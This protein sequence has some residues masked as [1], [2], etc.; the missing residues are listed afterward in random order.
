MAPAER[1]ATYAP[2]PTEATVIETIRYLFDE[3]QYRAYHSTDGLNDEDI[4]V[5]PGHG[6]WPIGEILR[7]QVLLTQFILETMKQGCTE[8]LPRFDFGKRGARKLAP[9]LEFR[10]LLNQ[11]FRATLAEMTPGGLMATRPD[12]PPDDWKDWPVLQ[13][14]LRPLTD[15]A[16]HTGQINYARRQLDKPVAKT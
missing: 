2:S 9:M 13:R 8:D 7:H 16:G 1:Y 12:S 6:S 5:D 10:E 11:R 14:L 15:I 3:T 4:N